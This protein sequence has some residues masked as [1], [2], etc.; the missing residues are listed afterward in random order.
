[1]EPLDDKELNS[2]LHEWKAPGAP[3]TLRRKILRRPQTWTQWLTKGTLQIP[4]PVALLAAIAILAVWLVAQR[5][6][7][8]A[9]I[10]EPVNGASTLADF[11]PVQQLE[12][13][14]MEKPPATLWYVEAD[15]A[16]KK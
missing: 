10:A 15:D 12:P 2:L 16:R 14:V 6:V 5:P 1:M 9:P 4:V 8:E 3:A 7:A 13:R 11:Q